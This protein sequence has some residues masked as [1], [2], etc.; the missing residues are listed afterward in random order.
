[1]PPAPPLPAVPPPEPP[2]I[3]P[4]PEPPEPTPAALCG[5]SSLH[6][7]RSST[8]T[9]QACATLRIQ[10]R[11]QR[12]QEFAWKS[13]IAPCAPV[14]GSLSRI[15]GWHPTCCSDRMRFIG[16]VLALLALAGCSSEDTA[17]TG[18][19]SE[20]SAGGATTGEGGATTGQGGG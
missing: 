2:F 3:E 11:Y 13:Q 15:A 19:T 5:D 1:M 14:F 18:G 17:A 8:T 16:W 4:A 10:T 12:N 20:S 7:T 6:P 9:T